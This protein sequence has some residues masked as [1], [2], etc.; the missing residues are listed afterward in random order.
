MRDPVW[1][2]SSPQPRAPWCPGHSPD[3]RGPQKDQGAWRRPIQGHVGSADAWAQP[4]CMVAYRPIPQTKGSV[5]CAAQFSP[6]TQ[7][8]GPLCGSRPKGTP[9]D[10]KSWQGPILG[11]V[12]SASARAQHFHWL[13]RGL[14]VSVLRT[15][16][17]VMQGYPNGP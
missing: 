7:P 14:G 15:V 2:R 6:V 9:K 16:P 12:G 3:L 10:Q 4:L 11:H 8:L 1:L 13:H 17:I 5:L